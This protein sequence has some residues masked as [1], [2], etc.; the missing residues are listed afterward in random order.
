MKARFFD[1]RNDINSM[2]E[3]D[4]DQRL[5]HIFYKDNDISVCHKGHRYPDMAYSTL[6]VDK[7]HH[8]LDFDRRQKDRLVH[9][10]QLCPAC[11]AVVTAHVCRTHQD[12]VSRKYGNDYVILND[13]RTRYNMEEFLAIDQRIINKTYLSGVLTCLSFNKEKYNSYNNDKRLHLNMIPAKPGILTPVR[14]IRD[15]IVR[16]QNLDK[17]EIQHTFSHLEQIRFPFAEEHPHH[18]PPEDAIDPLNIRAMV[19]KHHHTNHKG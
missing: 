13:Y 2:P 17:S 15:M 1:Y 5:V 3:L 10:Q 11:A 9:S 14:P 18:R 16:M 12:K 8:T 19:N 6:F 4:C 7:K